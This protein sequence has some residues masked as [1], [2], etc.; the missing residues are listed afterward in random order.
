MSAQL[1]LIPL[2]RVPEKGT[3]CYEILIAMQ[4]GLRVNDWIA[5]TQLGVYALSQRIGDLK[6]KFGWE[7]LIRERWIPGAGRKKVKEWWLE[8]RSAG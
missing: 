2:C 4:R 8:T 6:R 1:D 3:D 7:G 5:H